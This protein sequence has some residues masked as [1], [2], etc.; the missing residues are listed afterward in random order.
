MKST[1]I[2]TQVDF[3]ALTQKPSKFRSTH[4]KQVMFD[5]DTKTNSVP[6][7]TLQSYIIRKYRSSKLKPIQFQPYVEIKSSSIPHN[8][9]KLISTTY[10]R[11]QVN[12]SPYLTQVIFGPQTKK[13]S[14]FRSRTQK[15][16]YFRFHHGNQVNFDPH[17]NMLSISMP[18]HQTEIFSI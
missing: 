5:R 9:I 11:K 7:S 2:P 15:P 8:E 17:S 1:S 3:D 13:T 16:R 14:E 12:R 6:T 4:S 10:T 18:Q